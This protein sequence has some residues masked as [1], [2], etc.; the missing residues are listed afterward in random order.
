MGQTLEG[1]LF[2]HL[3]QKGTRIGE[4]WRERAVL[5]VRLVPCRQIP[6]SFKT[7]ILYLYSLRILYFGKPVEGIQVRKPGAESLQS[8]PE[9]DQEAVDSQMEILHKRKLY[10]LCSFDNNDEIEIEKIT[11]S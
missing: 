11:T 10:D 7:N 5:E 8:G 6:F 9:V 1:H 3:D 2:G 4:S